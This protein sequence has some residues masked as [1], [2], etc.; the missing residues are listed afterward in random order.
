MRM[1]VI[2]WPGICHEAWDGKRDVSAPTRRREI[3]SDGARS[4]AEYLWSVRKHAQRQIRSDRTNPDRMPKVPR[5]FGVVGERLAQVI[6]GWAG[7]RQ[8]RAEAEVGKRNGYLD[9]E[10]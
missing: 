4:K 2:A 9:G 8:P 3:S 1:F 10:Q 7:L 6:A 5:D